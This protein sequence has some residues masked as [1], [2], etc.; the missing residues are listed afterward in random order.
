M[1]PSGLSAS[2]IDSTYEGFTGIEYTLSANLVSVCI[3]AIF[4][5]TRTLLIPSSWIALRHWLPE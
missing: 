1:R 2:M 3:V 5:F 4:G